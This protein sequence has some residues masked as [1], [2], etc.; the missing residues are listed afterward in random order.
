[1]DLGG[2]ARGLA[3]LAEV[4]QPVPAYFLVSDMLDRPTQTATGVPVIPVSQVLHTFDQYFK[5]TDKVAVRSSAVDED[6]AKSRAG[7]YL[8]VLDVPRS[9]LLSAVAQVLA[10]VRVPDGVRGSD[11]AVTSAKVRSAADHPD[12]D[13]HGTAIVQ[14]M[15]P[16]ELSVVAFTANPLG[17]LNEAVVTVAAGAGTAVSDETPATTT[18]V[19]LTDGQMWSQTP[20]GAPVLPA[21]LVDEVVN[22]GRQLQALAGYPLDVEL[23]VADGQLWLLQARPITTLTL[24]SSSVVLDSSNIVESYPGLVS[25]LSA[26][27]I[28]LA[29]AGVFGSLAQRVTGDTRIVAAYRDTV[30]SMVQDHCGRMYY[31]ID[32]WYRVMQLVPASKWY[33]RVWQDSLGVTDREYSAPP[34]PL[35]RYLR[36]RVAVRLL[37]ELS[38]VP[39]GLA[40]LRALVV[41][42]RS[43]FGSRMD[44]CTRPSQL[45]E[46]FTHLH[47]TLFARWDV[48]LL[49]DVRAFVFPALVQLCLRLRRDKDPA[50]QARILVSTGMPV[51]SMQP[52]VQLEE[53][54]RDLPTELAALVEDSADSNKVSATPRPQLIAEIVNAERAAAVRAYVDGPGEYAGR[55]RAYLAEYG[56]R[57]FEELKLESVTLRQDP[58]LLVQLIQSAGTSDRFARK[59]PG[60]D[61][62]TQGAQSPGVVQTLGTGQSGPSGSAA[63]ADTFP[64]GPILRWLV[65]QAR[66]A[67]VGRE[68]SRLDRTRVYGMARD[69]VL[70]AGEMAVAAGRLD[71]PRDVFWLTLEEAFTDDLQ[72]RELIAQRKQDLAAFAVLPYY[73]RL[74]FQGEPFDRRPAGVVD[75]SLTGGLASGRLLGAGVSGGSATGRVRVV[76]DTASVRAQAGEILVTTM[77]DPGWV[78]LLAGAGAVIAER[79]SPLSHTAIVARELGVPMVV[80]IN[81]VTRILQDGDLVEVDGTAGIVRVL[82]R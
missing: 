29:Y 75:Q 16:A 9:E 28:P 31:R 34:V 55:L 25:P 52:L 24:G 27:F 60:R 44:A 80:G 20:P 10:S 32:S 79:G 57:C 3:W 81:Q 4:K 5:A 74:V 8:T 22:V 82:D 37:R 45:G 48:T 58:S 21:G 65:H 62:A 12:D 77:T 78:F 30:N 47:T 42:E 41:S 73:R 67:I 76:N 40:Q 1:M 66:A 39:A 53:L 2:K 68:S 19:N 11:D 64:R 35:S 17:I 61:S 23:A 50:G 63:A 14:A 13:V 43:T 7:H 15:L 71:D 18:Y 56:D 54:A 6:G 38:A 26:S 69:L 70:R 36:L 49:N 33:I 59:L 51:E 46:L 72:P